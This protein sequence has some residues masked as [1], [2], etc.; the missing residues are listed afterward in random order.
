MLHWVS[1]EHLNVDGDWPELWRRWV[2]SLIT[3]DSGTPGESRVY[4]VGQKPRLGPL[5]TGSGQYQEWMNPPNCFCP[6]SRGD[7]QK[8]TVLGRPHSEWRGLWKCLSRHDHTQDD[9]C[10]VHG[11]RKRRMQCRYH[12]K[13]MSESRRTS[14]HSFHVFLTGRLRQPAGVLWRTPRTGLLGSG[15]C[16]SQLPRSLRQS[17]WIPLLDRGSHENIL[18][19]K[20]NIN[21]FM[22]PPHKN[23]TCRKIKPSRLACLYFPLS[24]LIAGINRCR[25]IKIYFQAQN[26]S[27]V[28]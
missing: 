17:V 21:F 8:S 3:S 25:W 22:F 20:S 9:V 11:W 23:T 7:A 10:R 2:I 16:P 1:S 19:E 28:F 15:M 5:R 24:V 14:S 13:W 26:V 18:L 12:V 27:V 4:L 6:S